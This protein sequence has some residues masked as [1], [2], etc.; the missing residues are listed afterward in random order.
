MFFGLTTTQIENIKT[1]KD[2][3]SKATFFSTYSGTIT[4]IS[5]TEDDYPMEGSSILKLSDLNNLWLETSQRE[6]CQ[7][8]EIGAAC[9]DKL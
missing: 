8:L 4:E 7:K 9:H 1:G 5:A 6:L 3:L 2:I